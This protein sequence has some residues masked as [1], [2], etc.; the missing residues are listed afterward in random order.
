MGLRWLSRG[1]CVVL[2]FVGLLLQS[3]SEEEVSSLW[4]LLA[5]LLH[6]GN[7]E[8]KES[9]DEDDSSGLIELSSPKVTHS[10][11]APSPATPTEGPHSY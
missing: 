1:D 9:D 2:T 10:S 4:R 11:R 6:L 3:R 5:V 7:M 8:Y